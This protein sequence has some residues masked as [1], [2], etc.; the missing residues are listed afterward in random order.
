M[1]IKKP[2]LLAK[3][4]RDLLHKEARIRTI[5]AVCIGSTY[6]AVRLEHD[7]LGLAAVPSA[8]LSGPEHETLFPPEASLPGRPA[9]FLL[10]WLTQSDHPR[11]KALALATANA[12]IRQD[13]SDF[14]GDALDSF[15]LTAADSVV[16]VGRYTPLMARISATGA[17]LTV[18]EKNPAKGMVLPAVKRRS[19]LERGTVVI[20]TAT[21]M[22]YG[23]LEEILSDLGRPRHV[24]L[25]GPSTPM[26]PELFALTPVTHLGGVK[27]TD[28]DRIMSIVAAGGGTRAMRPG[29][30]MTNI[31]L[32]KDAFPG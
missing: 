8:A 17:A 4:L 21:A 23:D 18:L 14:D 16:M 11:Q 6:I 1:T 31:I 22:L 13:H 9:T 28:T 26:L 19:V 32:K 29:L 10:D 3:H 5:A 27:I 25:L 15:H 20:I 12:L 24:S 2:G 30:E 7:G